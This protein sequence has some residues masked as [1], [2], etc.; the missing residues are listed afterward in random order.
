MRRTTR[1]RAG[2]I[3]VIQVIHWTA[4]TLRRRS[5]HCA[6]DQDAA[7]SDRVVADDDSITSPAFFPPRLCDTEPMKPTDD[8]TRILTDLIAFDTTSRNSNLALIEYARSLLDDRAI[9]SEL[10]YDD[11]RG[12]A[13]LF[14]TLGA[15]DRPGI[16]LSGHTDVVPVDGQSWRTDPFAVEVRDD[17]LYGR[18]SCDMKGFIAICLAK[19]DYILEAKL[20][21]PIHFAL[22]YDEEVGC[23]GVKGLLAELRKREVQ[24]RACVIGEPTSMG[25]V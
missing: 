3:E 6:G 25:V 11:E 15:S 22:S 1:R 2:P 9:E 12:K 20:D 14:A 10:T 19:I 24:P 13:N 5:N 4:E 21:T 18:G 17:L 16:V 8:T 7:P 23:I